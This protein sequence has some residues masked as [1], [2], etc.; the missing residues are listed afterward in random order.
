MR[1]SLPEARPGAKLSQED[2][3]K[4]AQQ[5]IR[6]RFDLDPAAMR[7]V[8][9]EQQDRPARVDWQFTY[10]DPRV[11]VGKGGE[12][13]AIVGISGDEITSVGRYVFVPEDWQR[14]ERERAGRL[15]IA[16]MGIGLLVL[17]IAVA[18]L[19][20]A[21]VAWSRGRFDRRAFWRTNLCV[22]VALAFGALNQWPATAMSL[23]TAEPFT[24]QVLLWAGGSA[25]SLVL[26]TLL[27]GLIAGVAAWAA[28]ARTSSSA[29]VKQLYLRGVAAGLFVAGVNAL[30]A[31]MG[32]RDTP[33]WPRSGRRERVA[34]LAFRAGESVRGGLRWHGRD[35]VD[36]VL[37]GPVHQWMATTSMADVCR[38]GVCRSRAGGTLG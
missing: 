25:L 31:A 4:L 27:I 35:R 37:A 32:T 8:S 28:R 11:D 34:A 1:H 22:G 14:T 6:R 36:A 29:S 12:A 9:A 20:A 23:S 19:I 24:W 17:V 30:V 38:A 13:R 3:R 21:I 10:T 16:K 26:F 2:A 5:E 33:H 15:R 7:E 18:A